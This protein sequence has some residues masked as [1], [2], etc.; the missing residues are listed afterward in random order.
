MFRK[1]LD[2]FL[3]SFGRE[4]PLLRV[5]VLPESEGVEIA[6]APVE[7]PPRALA[8]VIVPDALATMGFNLREGAPGVIQ[9]AC[10]RFA[11]KDLAATATTTLRPDRSGGSHRLTA[12]SATT[13]KIASRK[14]LIGPSTATNAL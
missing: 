7:E 10:L 9:G 5:G 8:G 4:C 14:S 12:T 6:D 1:G 3:A 11:S 13:I 2:R